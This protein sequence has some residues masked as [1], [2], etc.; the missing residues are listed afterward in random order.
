MENNEISIEQREAD[1]VIARRAKIL[2]MKE[3]GLLPYKDKFERTHTILE[4]RSLND[5]DKCRIAGRIVGRRGFG[6]LM[7]LDLFDVYAKIQLEVTLNNLGEEKF[8]NIKKY[9]DH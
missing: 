3:N 5:G 8:A 6:K 1:E 9:M 4:A 2:D 7:F